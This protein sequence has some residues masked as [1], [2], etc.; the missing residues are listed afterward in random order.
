MKKLIL[1][2]VLA[3]I[4]TTII[5]LCSSDSP[6]KHE[7]YILKLPDGTTCELFEVRYEM[8]MVSTSRMLRPEEY[9]Q[10]ADLFHFPKS[11]MVYFHLNN[12]RDTGEQYGTLYESLPLPV[13]KFNPDSLLRVRK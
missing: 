12:L 13:Q 3:V 11:K 6:K 10:A 2:I 8:E 7:A 5:N 1:V 9:Q 4:A